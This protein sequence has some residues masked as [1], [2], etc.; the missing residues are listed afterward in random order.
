MYKIG[1]MKILEFK[2]TVRKVLGKVI[3]RSGHS[4]EL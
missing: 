4:V 2:E 3:T 1:K